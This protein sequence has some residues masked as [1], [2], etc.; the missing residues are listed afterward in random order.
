MIPIA[1]GTN[2]L[3]QTSEGVKFCQ[4]VT[5]TILKR[6]YLNKCFVYNRYVCVVFT[7]VYQCRWYQDINHG[8]TTQWTDCTHSEYHCVCTCVY[9]CVC[10]VCSVVLCTNFQTILSMYN[11]KIVLAYLCA[12]LFTPSLTFATTDFSV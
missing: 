1:S 4:A 11:F 12:Y 5:C 6:K 10:V 2:M 7:Y 8:N 3:T 9:M